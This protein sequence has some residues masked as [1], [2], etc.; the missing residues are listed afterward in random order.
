MKP[1]SLWRITKQARIGKNTSAIGLERI[2]WKV[3]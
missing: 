3:K 2:P 1:K